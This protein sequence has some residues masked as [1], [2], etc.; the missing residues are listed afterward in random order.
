MVGYH[1]ASSERIEPA[2]DVLRKARARDWACL[3]RQGRNEA[4]RFELFA[5]TNVEFPSQPQFAGKMPR[6]HSRESLNAANRQPELP[7]HALPD[8]NGC[9]RVFV[10]ILL[11]S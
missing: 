8:P 1:S 6:P 3:A 5:R 2:Q 10:E 7:S 11:I 9:N 4:H